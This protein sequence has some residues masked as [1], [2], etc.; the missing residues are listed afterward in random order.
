[1]VGEDKFSTNGDFYY[2]Y[3]YKFGEGVESIKFLK[4]EKIIKK[5]D[6]YYEGRDEFLIDIWEVTYND[7]T[8]K[9]LF[10]GIG[11]T[12]RNFTHIFDLGDF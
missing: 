8:K 1:M 11:K 9:Y 4:R 10:A 12:D 5:Y 3:F 2:N 7:K 6:D